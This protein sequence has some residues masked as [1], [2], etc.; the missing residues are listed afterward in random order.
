MAVPVG[1]ERALSASIKLRPEIPD[2]QFYLQRRGPRWPSVR[3]H[4]QSPA[5]RSMAIADCPDQ[6]PPRQSG[7]R[8]L[9]Q[10]SATVAKPWPASAAISSDLPPQKHPKMTMRIN[11]SVTYAQSLRSKLKATT[12][13]SSG[14]AS[15]IRP[16][17]GPAKVVARRFE[18]Y[19]GQR[20]AVVAGR[21][22]RPATQTV[23][24]VSPRPRH[25]MRDCKGRLTACRFQRVK[26]RPSVPIE[27]VHV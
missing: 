14:V 26:P 12:A 24:G 23:C 18:R 16:N 5:G 19:R 4:R 2:F 6:F 9:L 10:G 25:S 15:P 3:P 21:G 20:G 1:C 27:N 8:V 17:D 22:Q 11:R 7:D 13:I